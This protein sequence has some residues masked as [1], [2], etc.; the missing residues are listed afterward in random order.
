M[1]SYRLNR[2]VHNGVA[3]VTAV[4]INIMKNIGELLNEI[5]T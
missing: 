2:A 3:A 1:C 4:N 5:S